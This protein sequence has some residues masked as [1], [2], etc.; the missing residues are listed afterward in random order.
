M[1]NVRGSYLAAW[2]C[3]SGSR[4]D[5]WQ[6]EQALFTNLGGASGLSGVSE[7]HVFFDR[8]SRRAHIALQPFATWFAIQ[9]CGGG[10]HLSSSQCKTNQS[11]NV[12]LVYGYKVETEWQAFGVGLA[13]TEFEFDGVLLLIQE[14]LH[15]RS[16]A[17][18]QPKTSDVLYDSDHEDVKEWIAHYDKTDKKTVERKDPMRSPG[19]VAA[20]LAAVASLLEFAVCLPA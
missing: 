5:R 15:A 11:S 12:N 6:G 17:G 8:G 3:H 18:V 14:I 20:V 9:T 19:V 16:A 7:Q 10:W 1:I 2:H 4:Y 13:V